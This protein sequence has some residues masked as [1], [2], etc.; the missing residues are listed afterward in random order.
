MGKIAENIAAVRSRIAA[1]EEHAGRS[2]GSVQLM[3]AAKYQPLDNLLQALAAGERFFGH[4]IVQQ[5][6]T[7]EEGL[8]AVQLAS[9]GSVSATHLASAP[10]SATDSTRGFSDRAT[11]DST[12]SDRTLSDLDALDLDLPALDFS[13]TTTV[14]G[15]V[16]S[17]KL[18]AA[19]HYAQRIDT[20]DSFT[21]AEQIERR[22]KARIA[23]GGV[24]DCAYPI[25][26]QVNSSGAPTQ[27]GCE[28]GALID[29]AERIRELPHVR[30]DGL[31][32][33]GANTP[34]NPNEVIR[35]FELTRE[36]G[37]QLQEIPGL[38]KATTLSMGMS[39][40]LELAI[41]H[42]STEIRIGTAIFGARTQK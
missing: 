21:T 24:E 10:A 28:P 34:D 9:F 39:H 8:H 42:G 4:N 36:L 12:L 31:M 6:K 27:F 30:I 16:Q 22:Q 7:A 23:A 1:S 32:T 40:D 14:I 17:N 41:E 35:S 3:L 33:I 13:H 5:L 20:V 19:M 15:H 26:L 18:S 29:M 25:L 38:E 2:A 11:S 37:A